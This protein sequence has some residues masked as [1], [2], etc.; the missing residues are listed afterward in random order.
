MKTFAHT[1]SKNIL[2][3]ITF[4]LLLFSLGCEADLPPL[5]KY[6]KL[7]QLIE[8]SIQTGEIADI[9]QK[10]S[11]SLFMKS[12]KEKIVL[13]KAERNG[14]RSLVKDA[15]YKSLE[16]TARQYSTENNGV[17]QFDTLYFEDRTA[18]LVFNALSNEGQAN[19]V[20]VYVDAMEEQLFISDHL[21]YFGGVS[22]SYGIYQA[23]KSYHTGNSGQSY[24]RS[25]PFITA[26][27]NLDLARKLLLEGNCDEAWDQF[28]EVEKKYQQIPSSLVLKMHIGSCTEPNKYE[29]AAKEY[30]ATESITPQGRAYHQLLTAVGQNDL[31]KFDVARTALNNYIGSNPNIT[32]LKTFA[33]VNA[34]EYEGAKV[35]LDRCFDELDN[36]LYTHEL[37]LSILIALERVEE[38]QA[39][40]ETIIKQFD[41]DADYLNMVLEIYPMLDDRTD[42]SI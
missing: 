38:A 31:A 25:N 13:P 28:N 2:S 27:R 40:F 41:V 34:G 1:I 9:H 3:F 17:F 6:E 8:K 26:K 24:S 12:L 42:T 19:F 32:L 4:S 35:Y 20:D 22:F 39:C 29:E 30:I 10:F 11:A 37:K 23:A 33:L 36:A 5:E 18:H 14:I 21:N 7:A 15:F 16:E